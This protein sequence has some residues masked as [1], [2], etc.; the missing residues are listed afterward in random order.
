ME[1]LPQRR[2]Q[3]AQRFQRNNVNWRTTVSKTYSDERFRQTFRVSRTAFYFDLSKIEHRICKEFVVEAPINP[4]QRLVICLY[5]LARGDYLYPIGE[6]VGQAGSTVCQIVVEV[7]TTI[8]E[9]LWSETVEIHF[10]KTNDEFKEKLLDMDTEWQFPYAF[11]AID[12]SY[13]PI[14]CPSGG[15]EAMKQYHNLKN[16]YSGILLGLIY[17]NYRFIWAS[18]GA[19]G[20][21]HDATYFNDITSGKTLPGH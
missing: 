10:P 21:T 14:K 8:I 19:P 20:N 18:L 12:G 3:R 5:G 15:Q 4:D 13:L 17:G 11:A 6:M 9:E 2:L 16:F 7:C 1:T